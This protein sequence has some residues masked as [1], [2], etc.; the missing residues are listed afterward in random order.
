MKMTAYHDNGDD[1]GDGDG[2]GGGDV[3]GL[4]FWSSCDEDDEDK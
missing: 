2:D 3:V 1:C 4:W